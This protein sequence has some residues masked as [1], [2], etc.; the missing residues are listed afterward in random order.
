MPPTRPPGTILINRVIPMSINFSCKQVF[1]R[2]VTSMVINVDSRTRAK[3]TILIGR[4]GL[5]V[6]PHSTPGHPV[7]ILQAPLLVTMTDVDVID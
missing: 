5:A 2:R 4:E 3:T 7:T 1:V 6:R